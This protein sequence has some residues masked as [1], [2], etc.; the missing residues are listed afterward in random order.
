MFA[1]SRSISRG[2]VIS[3]IVFGIL[4]LYVLSIGPV[5]WLLTHNYI[6]PPYGRYIWAF[7][8]PVVTVGMSGEPFTT[9]YAWYLDIWQVGMGP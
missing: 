6:P 7:Y 8:W 5:G 4:A 3:C 2:V 1:A 9:V